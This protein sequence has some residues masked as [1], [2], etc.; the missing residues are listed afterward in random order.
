[1]VQIENGTE[2]IGESS[3]SV[4]LEYATSPFLRGCSLHK[5]AETEVSGEPGASTAHSRRGSLSPGGGLAALKAGKW[6]THGQ[7]VWWGGGGEG[8]ISSNK[9]NT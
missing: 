6:Q 3:D 4:G 8:G 7:S 5:A 9:K 2:G 1:M